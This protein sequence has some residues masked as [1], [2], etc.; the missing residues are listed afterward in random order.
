MK[1]DNFDKIG[2]SPNFFGNGKTIRVQPLSEYSN[3]RN[4]RPIYVQ[5]PI[6]LT[7]ANSVDSDQMLQ[8]AASD[9]FNRTLIK[10][11]K[12]KFLPTARLE[13]GTA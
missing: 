4:G 13:P 9:S 1:K 7:L 3:S 6:K 11:G 12:V 5:R 2:A 10:I 8:A